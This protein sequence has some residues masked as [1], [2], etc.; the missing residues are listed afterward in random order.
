MSVSKIVDKD[1]NV[2]FN[3][4]HA[5]IQDSKGDVKMIAERHGDL[6][7]VRESCQEANAVTDT[8]PSKVELWHGRFGHINFRDL[9]NMKRKAS[10]E[11]MD[12]SIVNIPPDCKICI[13]AKLPRLPFPK[14]ASRSSR[15]LEIIHTDLCGPMR[16]T[17][18]GGAKYFMTMIDDYSRWGD[19]IF[20]RS[21]D[22]AP[23]KL[24]QFIERVERQTGIKVKQVQSDNGKE[25][26]NQTLDS[27][28]AKKGIQRRLST[29]HTPQQNGVAERRNRTL[30][31]SAR[32]MLM[33]S[34]LPKSFWAE[35]ISTANYIRNSISKS[36][37]EG[38]PYER[39]FN[40][41]PNT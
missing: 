35:A 23:N 32:A 41:K 30:V 8:K 17:S 19:V 21:K 31:D 3:K 14:V 28:F 20:L 18:N 38:T 34:N 11:G 37:D 40:K 6:F 26:R 36:L 16:T 33:Q 2:I 10:V 13:A 39:W 24:I 15:K 27:Y 4:D 5:I 22:E 9:H 29:P 12:F 25:Y 1:Y 7:Y